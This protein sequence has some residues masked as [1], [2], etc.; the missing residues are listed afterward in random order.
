MAAFAEIVATDEGM[1]AFLEGMG[2]PAEAMTASIKRN[3]SAALA[4]TFAGSA[5]WSP[6]SDKIGAPSLWYAGS[7]DNGGFTSEAIETAARLGVETHL[8]PGADHVAT[9]RRTD[10]VL[11]FVQPFLDRYSS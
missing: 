8:M 6:S 4:A 7:D 10:D 3:D 1:T 2:T 11:A 9:F 5:E